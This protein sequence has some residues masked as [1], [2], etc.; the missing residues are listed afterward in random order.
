MNKNN[1]WRAATIL[2]LLAI[3]FSQ[4]A[5]NASA[6]PQNAPANPVTFTILH[7]NDF[8]GQL[9][10]SG[11]NPGMARVAN[12]VTT[13]RGTVGDSNML[14]LDD[15]D[16][17]QGSLLSNI[18]K[19]A[20]TIA[21]FNAMSYD[22]ATFGNH[23]FD[24]GQTVLTSRTGEATYPYL[25]ANITVKDGADC[26]S[27]SWNT[28]AFADAPY[29]LFTMGTSDTVKVAVIGV[30]SIETPTITTAS[31]TAGL[32]FKDPAESILHYYDAMKAA[33]A[34]VI[35]VLSHIGYADGGYGY[36]IPVY[37]DQ[38]LAAKLNTAGK[39]VNL[40]I[41]GHSHTDLA[42]A[43]TVGSTKVVQA[44][45]N[46]RKLGRADI[47]VGTDGSV[48]VN[49]TRITVGTSDPQDPAIDAMIDGYVADPAYQALINDPMGYVQ[50]DLLRNYNG[51]SMMGNFIDDSIYNYLNTDVPTTNDVDMFFNNAG[52]I[53]IDW[54]EK[55]DLPAN[56][57]TYIWSST[58]ADCNTGVWAHDPMVLT[59]GQM[60]QILPFGNQ[61][62]VGDMTGA[63]ILD[64]LHQSATLFK[65]AIQP[66]GIRYKFFR[67]SDANPG[68]QPY[69]WGA[70]D[71]E[72]YNKTTHVWEP[73]DLTKTYRVGTNEFLAPA[74]QDGYV[75]FKYMT[76]ITYWGDM[77]DAVNAYAEAN[78]TLAAPYKGPNGDGML[79]GRITRDGNGNDTYEAGEIVPL[80]VLHHNDSHGNLA[81]GTYVGY[82]QLV[83]LINQERAHN[84]SRTL[85]LSSGDNIQGDAMMYYFKS[86]YTGKT[87]D[88]TN[89]ADGSMWINPLI[90][91][92][93]L[94]GYDAMTLGNH[95]YN[96]GK[97]IFV[98]SLSQATFP[99]LQANVADD[100]SYG[101]ATANIQPYVEKDLGDIDVAILGIGNHRIPNYELPS[102]IP[103]LTFSNPID[104]AQELATL[105]GPTNDVVIAL[106]HIGFTEN[107]ASVEVD[108][109]VDTNLATTTNGIDAIIGGHSH[110]NP[111]SGFGAYK[112]L[113][114]LL[115]NKDGKPVVVT[116][117]YRYN[118]TLGEVSLGLKDLGSGSYDV[119]SQTGRY[120]SVATSTVEDPT[121]KAVV[122]PYVALLTSYN[123]TVIG[124][125]T[126]PM[127]ALTAYTQETT[128]ANIQA[129]ASVY[130]L[131]NVHGLKVDF[132]LS[133][134]MTN[135]K[136]ADTATFGTPYSLKIS[137]M[138]SLMPYE[139]SLVV[140]RMNGPQIKAVLERA[141][142]NY[143]YYK[144]VPN[145]GGYSYYTTCM[146]DTNAANEIMYNDQYPTLPN[147]NNVISFKVQGKAIDFTD[148]NTY[149]NVSTVNYLAAGS[150]NFNDGGVTLWPLNQIVYDTQ[151]Y[152]RD[153][154]IDYVKFMGTV[155]PQ[156]EGRINFTTITF[157]DV[158]ASYWAWPYI[159]TLYKAGVT[160]GCGSNNFC[161]NN[162]VTRAEMAVFILRSEHGAGYTPPAVGAS[163][164]FADVPTTH[165]A[166]AWIKQLAAEGITSGCGGGN[167][168]PNANVT[169]AQMAIFLLRGKYG[170]AYTPPAASG[171]L[172][173]DVPASAFASAWIEQLATEGITS[174]CGGSNYCPNASATRAQMAVFL[175]KTFGLP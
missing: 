58:A 14:L 62:I 95:E 76:N 102:N 98:G 125:T 141:Y 145:Q 7:T 26:A 41:G 81:K 155:T 37:G 99:L 53:R 113:P 175:V 132:H 167:Y 139:N 118:N 47:T 104:K 57:G 52:G 11:S 109:N 72:V 48:T 171:T 28:P 110:T 168:C 77:L 172:F 170:Q 124:N 50:T 1:L 86:A 115:S 32:C 150:C 5:T 9:E 111:A 123:N 152:V 153:A 89:I 127:D 79:D 33:G 134:A 75:P 15:G 27:S 106:T 114:S 143:Y 23:E 131:R 35:V 160:T 13:I 36:G 117:A 20:P 119:V 140:I 44:H 138:F 38:T 148:A 2:L 122:D 157:N 105:L 21:V 74:G 8:H 126:A 4:F 19:G 91:S 61:T 59:Y 55:E 60:F 90:K 116:Q 43:T 64:L 84:P 161:P 71:A 88:G 128:A 146:L 54:C 144:Y 69:G 97:D 92:F 80:T 67:Y 158:P 12:Y 63:Q 173:T 34:D 31:A 83:T 135:K 129:D 100:G 25:T 29:Q 164:G 17:M 82:T 151:Y 174:G 108:T 101:L 133:G 45:Y 147:G 107:P 46:G 70:Y 18:Q 103:G 16:E 163:T 65:G 51:D 96:F 40:I 85:L 154:V 130:E 39:P 142:R 120:I 159:E 24:W 66:A 165:W 162:N 94:V 56:P 112:Y 149:Y 136:V 6:A 42:A 49:W 22:A 3:L 87:S 30:T 93:N 156:I 68:P 10:P 73:L 121:I 137:D 78:Y 166:A 169:R